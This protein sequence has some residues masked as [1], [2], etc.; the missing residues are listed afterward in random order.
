MK[1]DELIEMLSTNLEPTNSKSRWK[2][3]AWALLAGGAAS[4]CM[5][6]TTI[7]LRA[8]PA[9]QFSSGLFALK[10]FFILSLICIGTALLID[11]IRP[12]QDGHKLFRVIFI[13][14]LAI[15]AAAAT[16]LAFNPTGTWARM[17]LGTQWAT[18]LLCIPLFAVVPFALLVWALRK[19][20][21]TNLTLTGAVAGLVAGALGA[22]I[23]ALHCPDDYVP[24][25]AIWYGATILLCAWI[26]ALIGPRFLRW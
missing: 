25:I 12:G 21:P 7:G 4:F 19:G 22:A 17:I 14:F 5:M 2:V 23:Y 24:F 18:C 3:F 6:V 13:P 16:T 9:V 8:N 11:L 10:S 20:A 1:T 26:G 15:G